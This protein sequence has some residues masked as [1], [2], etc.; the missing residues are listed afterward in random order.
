MCPFSAGADVSRNVFYS[1]KFFEKTSFFG[2]GN[3]FLVNC[4]PVMTFLANVHKDTFGEPYKAPFK[5]LIWSLSIDRK[6][7]E[8][9]RHT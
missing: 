7:T 3:P 6:K 1:V 2:G 4:E 9:D 8:L 5:R